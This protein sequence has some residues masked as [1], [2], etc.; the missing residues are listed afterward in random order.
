M[1]HTNAELDAIWLFC[2][3]HRLQVEASDRCGCFSC[4]AIFTNGE[5]R[6]WMD[7]P[8]QAHRGLSAARQ[9]TAVCPRCGIDAVLPGS[10]VP[11]DPDMLQAMNARFFLEFST[12]IRLGPTGPA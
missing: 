12:S 10:V 3:R 2:H 5:I 7:E 8:D 6:E 1:P 11:L 9:V 4:S